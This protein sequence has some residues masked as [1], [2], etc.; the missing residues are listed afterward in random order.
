MKLLL[1]LLVA[2]V[3]VNAVLLA[4]RFSSDTPASGQASS[5]TLDKS[6]TV[7]GKSGL[8]KPIRVS[9]ET[10]SHVEAGDERGVA[11][12][13]AAGLPDYMVRAIVRALIDEEFRQ[14]ENALYPD[15]ATLPYWSRN[16]SSIRFVPR[17]RLALID[18]RREKEARMKALLGS[19]ADP[20]T[21][22]FP[23]ERWAG[24][25]RDKAERL[26]Q[27][28]EDYAALTANIRGGETAISS[29]ML[30]SDRQK[31]AFLAKEK[32]SELASILTPA[33][34]EQYDLRQSSAAMQVRNSGYGFDMSEKEY[35]ALYKIHKEVDDKVGAIDGTYDP[36]ISRK[37]QQYQKETSEKI[38]A[39]LGEERYAEYERSQDYEFRTLS[40]LA[41]RLELPQ[42]KAF[43]AYDLK[44]AFEKKLDGLYSSNANVADRPAA[45]QALRAEAE[46]RFTELL[47]APA[48]EAFKR[49]SGLFNRL[50]APRRAVS[51]PASP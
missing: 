7:G 40:R 26:G 12:L 13:R 8:D 29:V 18:L 21:E 34:L 14:R 33:E 15:P 50:E 38:K 32:R 41:K 16:Y 42:D 51:L 10:W 37:R 9:A 11:G 3:S 43:A 46:A 48:T 44:K 45:V 24:L 35:L 2:S 5:P 28:E 6:S 1:L 39:A 22:L 25:P 4:R 17:D 36:E 47:G 30:P 23:D 20:E 27:I 19:V 49:S 31:L